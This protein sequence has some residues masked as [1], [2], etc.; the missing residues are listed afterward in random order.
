MRVRRSLLFV[1]GNNPGMVQTAGLFGADV[2]IL[3]LE[4]A[5]APSEKDAARE[6]VSRALVSVDY[7]SAE[8]CVRINSLDTFFQEDL[9]AI[10]PSGPNLVMLPKVHSP[11][12]V[13]ALAARLDSL[14]NHSR[15]HIRI[16]AIIESPQGLAE[17]Y[18]I[19]KSHKRLMGLLMG[20]EDYTALVGSTRTKA[21]DELS[22]PRALL[23]N[24]AA[25]A[26]IEAFDA[27]FTDVNDEDGLLIDTHLSKSLG[28][29]GKPAI[30]PRQI[31]TINATFNPS[32]EEIAQAERVLK[33][34]RQ[35]EKE[36]SGVAS[37]GGKMV[38]AP[39]AKRAA[40][41]MNLARQL[42]LVKGE[43]D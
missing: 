39:V 12:D 42:G 43:S 13:K 8:K 10:V 32:Q 16:L 17:V 29:T 28:F 26:G 19:A 36:G 11:D 38:D 37:V 40:R 9:L 5:V 31:K 20:A 18:E 4:D 22:V 6:L 30:N 14:E 2:V 35:A 41:V 25:A 23:V 33:A 27:V 24:A 7:G 3:D 1:P 21:G 15:K 34:L